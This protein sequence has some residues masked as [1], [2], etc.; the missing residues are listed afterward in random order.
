ME[1]GITCLRK[2]R[3]KEVGISIDLRQWLPVLTVGKCR[4]HPLQGCLDYVTI[5]RQ[6]RERRH[7]ITRC[8]RDHRVD[9]RW[10]TGSSIR[11][12]IPFSSRADPASVRRAGQTVAST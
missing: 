9:R 3:I 12:Q 11:G 8:I 10:I 1:G 6:S 5:L 2:E 7:Q 4:S